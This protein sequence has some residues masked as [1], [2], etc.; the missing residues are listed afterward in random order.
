M[1]NSITKEFIESAVTISEQPH[2]VSKQVFSLN[3]ELIRYEGF[4]TDNT[5]PA[6]WDKRGRLVRIGGEAPNS[7]DINKYSLVV[8][9][10]V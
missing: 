4:V 7:E 9:Q 5:L 10:A 8:K 6:A 3:G 1:K 2:A